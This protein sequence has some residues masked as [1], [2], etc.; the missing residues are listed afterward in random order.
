MDE[1]ADRRKLRVM[2]VADGFIGGGESLA[3]KIAQRLDRERFCSTMC[4]TRPME[5]TPAIEEGLA[6]LD[7]AGAAVIE[8]NRS[9]RFSLTPWRRLVGEMRERRIDILH[10]HMIGPNFWG[11]L[12]AP[13]ARVPV[14]I[15]HEHTWSWEGQPLRRI[16]DRQ[17]IARRA[18]AFVAVSRFDQKQMTKVEGIP[19]AKTRFVP[20]GIASA[21]RTAGG[22]GIRAELGIDPSQP[23]VGLVGFLRPQ[24]AYEVMLE[25]TCTLLQEFPNLRVLIVGGDVRGSAEKSRLERLVSE[26]GLAEVVSFLDFRADVLDVIDAFDVAAQTSD[27]EGTPQSILE[28]MEAGKPVV[29]TRVGGVP[30]LVRDGETGFLVAPRDPDGL[31]VSIGNLLRDPNRAAAM[32]RAGQMLRRSE[33]TI[34]AMIARIEALYE[35]LWQR[36]TSQYASSS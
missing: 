28:F 7:A 11:A 25:A 16:I 27:F 15:A 23:V 6:E 35:E 5:R 26:L 36:A 22:S 2:T 34:E 21:E 31:A 32:G 1:S 13:R 14:F 10:T 20:I 33:F 30:D 29:A 3:R 17:L 8:L 19:P 18:D 4:V 24:K 9:A 12:L